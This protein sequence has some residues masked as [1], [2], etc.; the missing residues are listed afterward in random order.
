MLSSGFLCPILHVSSPRG[1]LGKMLP[2]VTYSLRT[3]GL[4]SIC[5]EYF[6]SYNAENDNQCILSISSRTSYDNTGV[7]YNVTR[8]LTPESTI[9]LKA[10]HEYSP[11]FIS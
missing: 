3:P 10:Y 4:E 6:T 1:S 8:I 5:R 9:D 11:L 7:E 2:T